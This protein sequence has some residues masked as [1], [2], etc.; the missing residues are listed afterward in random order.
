MFCTACNSSLHFQTTTTYLC[1][2]MAGYYLSNNQICVSSCGDARQVAE[3]NCDDGNLQEGDGCSSSC[4]T[5]TNWIC[6]GGTPTTPST[7]YIY[8]P[9]LVMLVK[10]VR[11]VTSM[12]RMQVGIRFV[13]NYSQFT[14]VNFKQYISHNVPC[15]NFNATYLNGELL[16]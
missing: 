15:S 11:R 2:C 5:E 6:L 8:D 7:C 12:N 4:L 16:L 14:Q 3:E 9:S 13:P 10:F 1:E